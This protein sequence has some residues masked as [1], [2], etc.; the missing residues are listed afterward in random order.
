MLVHQKT[1]FDPYCCIK[2]FFH[3]K[4]LEKNALKSSFC[5]TIMTR[6]SMNDSCVLKTPCS[7]AKTHVILTSLITFISMCVT[8]DDVNLVMA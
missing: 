2:S 6:K 3:L 5:I 8:V 4:T 7:R 1:M